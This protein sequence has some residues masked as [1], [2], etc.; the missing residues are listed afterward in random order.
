M[1]IFWEDPY[2]ITKYEKKWNLKHSHL[3]LLSEHE[4]EGLDRKFEEKI[5]N[6]F[7]VESSTTL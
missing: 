3:N 5:E 7:D 2:R 4:S 6:T 1:V